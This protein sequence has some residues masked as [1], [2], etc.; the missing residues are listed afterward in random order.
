MGRPKKYNYN[1]KK[2]H[3]LYKRKLDKG[4]DVI[5]YI[6][7]EQWYEAK[8]KKCFYC[9]ITE[10]ESFI[11]FQH[12]PEATRGGHRGKSIELERKHPAP[13]YNDLNNFDL[14]CY[15]CNNAKSNYFTV[16]EFMPIAAQ[17]AEINRRRL[18]EILK[19]YS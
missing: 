3:D 15:W 8:E 6:E 10:E 17:I 12:Y 7:F 1:N 18:T 5:P 4:I 11:L 9:G 19:S 16:E 13:L 2:C 14:A